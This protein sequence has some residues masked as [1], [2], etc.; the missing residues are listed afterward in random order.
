MVDPRSTYLSVQVLRGLAAAVVEAFHIA[1]TM[2][3]T[4]T[5]VGPLSAGVDVFFVISEFVMLVST[6]GRDMTRGAFVR[7]RLIRVVPL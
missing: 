3:A 2:G 7:A 5:S 1:P 4:E 6:E